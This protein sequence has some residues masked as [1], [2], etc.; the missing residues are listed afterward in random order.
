VVA[1][2]WSNVAG[3]SY[4]TVWDTRAAIGPEWLHLDLRLEAWASDGLLA[5]FFFIAGLEIKR[6]LVVGELTDRRTAALPFVAAVGGMVVPVLVV[7]AVSGGDA[8]DS[9]GP[10]CFATSGSM[11]SVR[12]AF[13]RR[14]VPVSSAAVSRL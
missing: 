14:C 13:R 7:L 6:E 12:S 3:D 4:E 5:I 9:G 1:L 11:K 2:L 10:R 8:W